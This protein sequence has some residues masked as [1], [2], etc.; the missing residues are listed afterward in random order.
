MIILHY[1]SI[2]LEF[3]VAI[4]GILLA[5]KKKKDFGWFIALTFAIYVFYDLVYVLNINMP[6]ESLYVVFFLA[7]ASILWAVWNIYKEK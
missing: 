6:I 5:T 7:T 3:A 2:I 1:L 4:L